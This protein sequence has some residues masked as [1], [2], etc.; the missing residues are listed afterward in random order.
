MGEVLGKSYEE[1]LVEDM[2]TLMSS[3]SNRIYVTYA[4]RFY[5]S[6]KKCSQC[7]V[8]KPDLKL[9]DRTYKCQSCGSEMDRDWNAA[10]NL[11]QYTASSSGINAF[12]ERSSGT[13][14]SVA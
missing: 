9:S 7:G 11:E 12:G 6:S 1:E 10:K 2:L 4:D 3:F 8:I 14:L 5:P 13:A